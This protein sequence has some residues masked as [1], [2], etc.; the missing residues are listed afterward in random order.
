MEE[1][2]AETWETNKNA[3]KAEKEMA[4][5][6]SWEQ[7]RDKEGRSCDKSLLVQLIHLLRGGKGEIKA[8]MPLRTYA[9]PYLNTKVYL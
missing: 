8:S 5:D 9:K 7:C 3:G 1:G 2:K 4:T 6:V